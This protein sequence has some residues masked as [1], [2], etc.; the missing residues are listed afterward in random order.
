MKVVVERIKGIEHLE[1]DIPGQ[2][3]WVMTGLNGAGKSTLLAALY[4]IRNSYAFQQYF[5]TSQ[6]ANRID[7]YSNSSVSYEI[8]GR[9]VAY[10]YGGQRWRATPRANAD[11][12]ADFPYPSIVYL[13]ANSDRIEPFSDEIRH[14]RFRDADAGMRD[15]MRSVLNDSKW[16]DLK[17][18]NTRRGRG[19]EAY[20]I[21]YRP[22]PQAQLHYYSE[23][24]FS[25]GELCVLRLAQR[26]SD[27]LD[28]SLILI[29]E[30]EMALHPQ[31]QVR[32]LEN[33]SRI[34]QQK[35]LT[36]LFST[37]SASIIKNGTTITVD[38]AKGNAWSHHS[39]HQE[40]IPGASSWRS[41]V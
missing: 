10:R 7:V 15:F 11:L 31:A 40:P 32:L 2:G 39:G 26:L 30:I 34:A 27:V 8:N 28:E 5:Q 4:R 1:F 29:D 24:S 18:L 21:P 41:G 3:V 19:S 16:T 6:L 37:H 9:S 35:R 20:L 17:Y 23:K 13:E 25:L 12:F 22:R 33:L 14:N 36:V 38:V